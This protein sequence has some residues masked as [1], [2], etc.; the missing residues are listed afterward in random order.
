MADKDTEFSA[1]TLAGP[2]MRSI[3][4]KIDDL[5]VI[6]PVA[7]Q[8]LTIS[9][10][11]DVDLKKLGGV[12]ESDPILTAKILKLVNNTEP[13]AGRK[14]NNIKQ[15][16]ARA[17][18]NQVRCALLG[19]MFRE[20]LSSESRKISD[21]S[22]QL[23]AHSL[24]SAVIARLI[25]RQ[26]Y[27]ELQDAAFV[28]C[29]LH[30]I[31]KMIIMDTFPDTH[32]KIEE[33]KSKQRIGSLE[34]EQKIM[35]TNHGIVGKILAGQ[36][37]FPDYIVDC[38]S[39][40][41]YSTDPAD[42]S[43]SSKKLLSISILGNIL[44]H[45]IFCDHY[46]ASEDVILRKQALSTIGLNEN[47]TGIIKKDATREYAV[48][49]E[50][51]NLESDLNSLFHGI[52]QKA[53]KKLSGIGLELELKNES[54]SRNN[55]ILDLAHILGMK[56]NPFMEK[57]DIFHQVAEVFISFDPAEAGFFYS[58]SP[59]T[60]ELEG[61]FWMHGGHKQKFM[62]FLDNDG[63]PVWDQDDQGLPPDL[64]SIISRYSGRKQSK[65]FP[66]INTC[67]PFEIFSFKSEDNLFGELCLLFRENFQGLTPEVIKVFSQISQMLKS[68][69]ERAFLYD[70]LEKR[71]EE[72]SLAIWKNRQMNLELMQAERLAAVGQL[73]AGAAHEINN[74][75][76]IISARAQLLQFREEDEKKQKELNLIC[77]Q[78]ER[79]SK[80]LSNLMDFARPVPPSLQETDVHSILDRVLEFVTSGFKKYKISITRNYDPDLNR[81][82][83][84][85]AQLE[86]VFLNL[87]I[88]AQHAMEEKG[89]TLS[90][91]TS[92]SPDRE[93]AR[94]SIED[95][96]VGIS[97]ENLEKVFDPFFTT[98][99][100][101]K[102]TGLGLS[103]SYGII[104]N[105]LG[106]IDIDSEP[107]RGTKIKISLPVNISR[108]KPPA[109]EEP[110]LDEEKPQEVRP[111]ILI[112]D[113]EEHIRDVLK[114]TLENENMIAETA[115]NGQDGLEKMRRQSYDLLLLDIK[116]PLRDG[117]SL[118]REVRK[119]DKAMPVI[120]ITGMA[121]NEEM[122]EAMEHGCQC[123]RKPFHIKDLLARIG[124]CLD[125]KL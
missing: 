19:V 117:L 48:K 30:D 77:S 46:P 71:T 83:A 102:G 52:V 73:A 44:A 3:I 109:P 103:T 12:V 100:Q 13:G 114:E 97:R 118:L 5:P 36:W 88:N 42:L 11:D 69:L 123:I 1:S 6:P 89:G 25:S 81:I 33:L 122:Q 28:S 79:I 84:D 45:E 62:C 59:D 47:D 85:P 60:R 7:M 15:A 110:G 99:E 38:I 66:L 106:E 107:G 124:E 75:L 94:I 29:L 101:G 39:F 51:F 9:L 4:K 80:I 2:G 53:N 108:L 31:G 8:A 22:K 43:S 41:H 63:L 17:G 57:H 91:S 105:H 95:Q 35:E 82:K 125:K 87:C 20:R 92:L 34:A 40:H 61:V 58:I 90:V 56:L 121:S 68:S 120:V 96:G 86:Q 16:M 116:M 65:G 49:A 18:L 23:W 78:I 37:N 93:F 111:R 24:M 14:T 10:A 119:I 104:S 74:P 64:K 27:P 70:R 55:M 113:D 112:A 50:V 26:T 115:V 67:S 72:L 76:A 98:K 32:L 21:D 54:L